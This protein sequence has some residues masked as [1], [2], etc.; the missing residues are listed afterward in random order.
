MSIVNENPGTGKNEIKE[1]VI[2]NPKDNFKFWSL[3]TK[4]VLLSCSIMDGWW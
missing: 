1:S 4:T 3:I 2:D